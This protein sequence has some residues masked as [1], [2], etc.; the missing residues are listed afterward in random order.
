[1]CRHEKSV[2]AYRAETSL[3]SRMRQ[4]IIHLKAIVST[5]EEV[6]TALQQESTQL[7]IQNRIL[8]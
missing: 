1:M 3:V 2:E 7:K 6:I 8:R 4:E 5:Q